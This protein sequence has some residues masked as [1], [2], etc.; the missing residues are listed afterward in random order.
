MAPPGPDRKRLGPVSFIHERLPQAMNCVF[1]KAA[2]KS[3]L[4]GIP[5]THHA[6][7]GTN[8]HGMCR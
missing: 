5:A 7:E 1:T 4:A 6:H 3:T 8:P 2:H